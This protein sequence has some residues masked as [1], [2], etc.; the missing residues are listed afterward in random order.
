MKFVSFHLLACFICLCFVT[1][2]HS[3]PNDATG[4]TIANSKMTV[5]KFSDHVRNTEFQ[6]PEKE[7]AGFKLPPGF[8]ITLYASEPDISK[9]IN[10]EFDAAGKL[11]VTQSSEYP[12]AADPENGHDRITVLEDTDN[13][14]KADKFTRFGSDLNIPIGLIPVNGG[15]I[16]YSIPNIYRFTD[17]DGDG[18]YDEKK[19]LFGPFGHQDTHGMVSNFIKGYDGWIHACHGFTNTSTIAGTDGDSITMI[20][21][22]TFRFKEDGTHVEQT[23]YGR[24][25]PFGFAFDEWGYLYSVDCHSKP[26]YQMISGAEYP[27]FGKKSPAIGFAPEMMSYELGSTAL[28]GLVYYIGNN[29]PAEYQNSFYNGD[30]VTCRINRNTVTHQGSSPVS[31]R[32]ADFLTSSDPW[33]RPVNIKMGPDG[34]MYVADF[35]NKIIGHYEVP[36]NHPGRDKQSGRI[37]KITYAGDKKPLASSPSTD[38]SK[39]GLKELITN[40]NHAQLTTRMMI[41]NQI[42]DRFGSRA[43]D[44]LLTTIKLPQPDNKAFIQSLW[45]LSRLKALPPETLERSSVDED[46]MLQVHA[47]RIM[48]EM[49]VI[50]SRQHEL[51]LTAMN[52]ANA[53]VQ[54]MATEVLAKF[55]KT[56]NVKALISMYKKIHN[57]DN[58]LQYTTLVGVRQNLRNSKVMHDVVSMKWPEDQLAVLIK[59]IPDVPLPEAASYALDYL[60]N[61]QLPDE[62]LIITME[63][64]GR[65]IA[66]N[67]LDQ[68][69]AFIQKKFAGKDDMQYQFY[70]TVKKGLAQKGVPPSQQMKNWGKGMAKA[71]LQENYLNDAGNWWNIIIERGWQPENPW[72]VVNRSVGKDIEA[73]T[74]LWSEYDW[75][76]TGK[77]HSPVFKLPAGLSMKVYD[78]EIFKTEA[79]SGTSKNVVRIRLE[80]SQQIVGEYR[81]ASKQAMVEK[82]LIRPVSFDLSKF[83]GQRGYIEVLDS[84]R[85]GG[86]GIGAIEPA[87][88]QL[89]QRGPGEV[90][91]RQVRAAEIIGDYKISEFEPVLLTI[92]NSPWADQKARSASAAALMNISPKQYGGVIAEVFN[93]ISS[94]PELRQQLAIAL[95]QSESPA[96]FA[97]LRK[98][99]I[100]AS[101][102]LQVTLAGLFVK[103][104]EG[105]GYLLN[106]ARAGDIELDVLNDIAIKERLEAN[107]SGSQQQQLA[108]LLKGINSS[109]DRK[110]IIAE[111]I[112]NFD[113]TTVTLE[114]G[115][116]VFTQNC[117][118][119]HQIKGVGGLIGP[120]LNGIGNWGLKSLSEKILNPNASI[121]EAFRMY[122]ITLK[123][124]KAV[125][126]LFRREEGQVL[127]FANPGG[128]EFTIG[129]NDIKEKVA[130]KYTLMP[131]QFKNTLQK[132]DFD[133]LMKFLLRTKE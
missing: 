120:Q 104:R 117:S 93:N 128:Q 11:W 113:S 79:K 33:F 55:P 14:G 126:G 102:N 78:S 122:N 26:I 132:N 59:V 127:I 119:C 3:K 124:G 57:S 85:N 42:F 80:K 35:Y 21:G 6:T 38:W 73:M 15:A 63:Y 107:T 34:A 49:G 101:R 40:L 114:A 19:I 103:S 23:T 41:A 65:Y 37:W 100:G 47:L 94:S 27:H 125:S 81:F 67:R 44:P 84:A 29:F 91:L 76:P 90:G 24:V 72:N 92:L 46:P 43:V 2:Q 18:I 105:I 88:V 30:V 32:E 98:G 10:M 51:V 1:C 39:A 5:D 77:L 17:K 31:K 121:S 4:A 66:A 110:K 95:G 130:S 82:D 115:Q 123:N 45:L 89:P 25:N 54:R 7:K 87:V 28:S 96:V 129:K 13:N 50:T 131:D 60:Q 111:R 52:S 56:G 36:L 109:D 62:Q 20:S 70:Q 53:N 71:F 118:M 108:G 9:P 16:G 86:I 61:H 106:A 68:A 74:L 22:N 83:K 8:E 58:H 97:T 48:K 69:I 99:L 133:A 64:I 116:Q 75:D 112:K 12:M